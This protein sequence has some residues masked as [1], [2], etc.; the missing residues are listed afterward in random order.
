MSHDSSTAASGLWSLLRRVLGGLGLG[1]TLSTTPVQAQFPAAQPSVPAHWVAYAQQVSAQFQ[2]Q[3]ADAG[4]P[5]VLRLHAWMQERM[6]QASPAPLAPLRLR[7][8]VA[9][10]G[11]VE[12]LEFDS[13]GQAQ[14]DADL[15]ELLSVP[16][17]R[18]RPP[19][20]LRQPMALELSL[21]LPAHS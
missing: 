2:E 20:D 21:Y 10:A 9:P 12:R 11:R 7:V 17:L 8:W 14:A 4:N 18:E 1:L 16:P 15:H 3:L 19:A 6:Q 5:A 13:L